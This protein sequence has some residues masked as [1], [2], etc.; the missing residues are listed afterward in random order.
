M[1]KILEWVS[2]GEREREKSHLKFAAMLACAAICN[3]KAF[4]IAPCTFFIRSINH[5]VV[6]SVLQLESTQNNVKWKSLELFI[7]TYFAHITLIMNVISFYIIA[8]HYLL[9]FSYLIRRVM[10]WFQCCHYHQKTVKIIH[11]IPPTY[12]P[13]IGLDICNYCI[14]F[15]MQQARNHRCMVWNRRRKKNCKKNLIIKNVVFV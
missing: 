5:V 14:L 12:I 13:H 7:S 8:D 4:K 1:K 2:E 15:T 11:L 9:K 10:D 6:L 3:N